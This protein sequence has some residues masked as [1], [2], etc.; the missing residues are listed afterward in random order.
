M[1][2]SWFV[3]KCILLSSWFKFVSCIV[4]DGRRRS[5]DA[6]V[7]LGQK[8]HSTYDNTHTTSLEPI[9]RS[10]ET[11]Y[12]FV[13][14]ADILIWHEGDL[15]RVDISY[16]KH[17][18]HIRFCRLDHSNGWGNRNHTSVKP[19][20]IGANSI[21]GPGYLKMIRFYSVTIWNILHR[22]GYKWMIRFDDDSKLLST[23]NYN[24]FDFMRD[25]KKVYGYRA[26]SKECG[27]TNSF[28]IFATKYINSSNIVGRSI[29]SY[30]DEIGS[31][32]Y[33]NNFYVSE[34]SWWREGPV[35]SFIDAFDN[36]N[37][38]FTDRDN[39]LIFQTAAVKLFMDP[40]RVMHF[41][42]WS[43]LHH[44]IKR[45][46]VVWGGVETGTEDQYANKTVETY[47]STY[48]IP[49]DRIRI[50]HTGTDNNMTVLQVGIP[51]APYCDRK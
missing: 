34:I 49:R 21:W 19:L 42:D 36:S 20:L 33:Y 17:T 6:I 8:K 45:G 22:L 43:Y 2:V 35:A 24:L 4:C 14:S 18:K 30:C 16:L 5:T 1:T 26:L 51:E 9:L 23:I 15:S 29:Q 47:V 11:Y 39:D 37:I 25:N 46:K 41:I 7:I 3:V 28:D 44:T 32:G 31:V 27:E 10:L 48:G 13:R 40:E 12:L 38:I 50:C